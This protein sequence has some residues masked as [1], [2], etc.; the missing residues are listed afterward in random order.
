M[1]M[2]TPATHQTQT[3][4]QNQISQKPKT[5]RVST[6]IGSGCLPY[7]H[8]INSNFSKKSSSMDLPNCFCSSQPSNTQLSNKQSQQ[9][10]S[11]S[12]M[13]YTVLIS[14]CLNSLLT[15]RGIADKHWG[16]AG[17]GLWK[18]AF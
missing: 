8:Q 18:N 15:L 13:D 17:M 9:E 5:N 11:Q 4:N 12:A 2:N 16:K 6:N 10:L 3:N 7:Q 14:I 1:Q